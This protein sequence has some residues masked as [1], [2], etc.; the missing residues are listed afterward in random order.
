[1]F[2]FLRRLLHPGV[3]HVHGCPLQRG[4]AQV[5]YG[6]VFPDPEERPARR[7]LFPNAR[8]VVLGGCRVGPET[9]WEVRFCPD[10]RAAEE[11][12]LREHPR[13]NRSWAV[14]CEVQRERRALPDSP[15]KRI[16]REHQVRPRHLGEFSWLVYCLPD[17]SKVSYDSQ[18]RVYRLTAPDL[19]DQRYLEDVAGLV[20]H[21]DDVFRDTCRDG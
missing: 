2:S 6:L 8:T 21:L 19:C 7:R 15:G 18:R 17:G 12:W 16:L 14:W 10:C 9:T 11:S 3:C 5:V 13:F 4:A 20:T 1:M